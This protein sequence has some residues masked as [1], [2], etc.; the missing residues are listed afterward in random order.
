MKR[1][2]FQVGLFIHVFTFFTLLVRVIN[3]VLIFL[4]LRLLIL[5]LTLLFIKIVNGLV[6]T[7][8]RCVTF[9]RRFIIPKVLV[10]VLVLILK[11]L[12]LRPIKVVTI[13]LIKLRFKVIWTIISKVVTFLNKVNFLLRLRST[14]PILRLNSF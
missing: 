11:T 8:A 6:I 5:G 3:R 13:F 12:I 10:I 4:L 14:R 7:H 9:E 1:H 2:F